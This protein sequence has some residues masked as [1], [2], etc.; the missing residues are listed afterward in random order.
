[1]SKIIRL[2]IVCKYNTQTELNKACWCGFFSYGLKKMP[3][4]SQGK[5]DG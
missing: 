5:E 2:V 3:W 1:M 4:I